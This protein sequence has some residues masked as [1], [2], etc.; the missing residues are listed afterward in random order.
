VISAA[1]SVTR[2]EICSR[3]MRI[4]SSGIESNFIHELMQE[5]KRDFLQC[6]GGPL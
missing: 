4:F 5:R 1:S 2:W 3:E 6:P